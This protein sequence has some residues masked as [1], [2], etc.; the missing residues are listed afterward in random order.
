MFL[1]SH[2]K[3]YLFPSEN[4]EFLKQSVTL[5]MSANLSLMIKTFITFL[6]RI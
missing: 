4:S 5:F 1:F 3:S 6:T 2:K